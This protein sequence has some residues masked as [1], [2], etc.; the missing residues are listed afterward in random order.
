MKR[1]WIKCLSALAATALLAFAGCSNINGGEV[2]ENGTDAPAPLQYDADGNALVTASINGT[3]ASAMQ[4]DLARTVLPTPQALDGDGLVYVLSG[5][6]TQGN[7]IAAYVVDGASSGSFT[8]SFPDTSL[9][10]L[11]LTAYKTT[12][13][14]DET[15]GTSPI[16]I[17]DETYS[18]PVLTATTEVDLST[19]TTPALVF[20]MSVKGLTT[21]GSVAI[22][23]TAGFSVADTTVAVSKYEITLYDTVNGTVVQSVAETPADVSTGKVE[24]NTVSDGKSLFTAATLS[25]IAPSEYLLGITFYNTYNSTDKK[26][27]FWSDYI[28]V[29][30]GQTTTFDK[31]VSGI[32]EKPAAP[33]NFMA[34]YVAG[35]ATE[36]TYLVKLTWDD[37]S[38]NE[39]NFEIDLYEVTTNTTGVLDTANDTFLARLGFTS[40]YSDDDIATYKVVDFADGSRYYGGGSLFASSET[41]TLKLETGKLYEVILRAA[42]TADDKSDDVKRISCTSAD[43]GN[44]AYTVGDDTTV[45]HINLTRLTYIAQPYTMTVTDT[46]VLDATGSGTTSYTA[47]TIYTGSEISLLSYQEEGATSYFT[48]AYG[49]SSSTPTFSKWI[50]AEDGETTVASATYKNVSV[51]ADVSYDV[52]ANATTYSYTDDVDSSFVTLTAIPTTGDEATLAISSDA[53]S[54]NATTYSKLKIALTTAEAYDSYRIT[55]DGVLYTQ[56]SECTL[57]LSRFESG[58]HSV[59]VAGYVVDDNGNTTAYSYSFTLKVER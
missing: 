51:L 4:A 36:D 25:D 10:E 50:S 19:G 27:G 28:V 42:L 52:T 2:T 30:P 26:V 44:T 54:V 29:A 53:A 57:Y 6:S 37:N 31:I 24:K 14:G 45:A 56:K 12:T 1:T 59:V 9:W 20:N 33:E 34:Q 46:T 21:P 3:T 17:G 58:T 55:V 43:E 8:V 5:S 16:T 32:N 15:A 47:Y 22:A 41:A 18:D 39:S 23:E 38:T 7:A 48:L 35:S 11:T 49:T 13:T 40:L